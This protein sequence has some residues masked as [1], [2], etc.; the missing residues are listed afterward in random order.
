MAPQARHSEAE[1]AP[2]EAEYVPAGH[3]VQLVAPATSDQVPAGQLVQPA[4]PTAPN[5]PATHAVPIEQVAEPAVDDDPAGHA[6]Q[7]A[8]AAAEAAAVPAA[9]LVHAAAP[10]SV[11]PA[12]PNLPEVQAVPRHAAAEVALTVEE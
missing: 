8:P 5:W 10:S 12:G 7:E 4:T 1:L 3:G 6:G 11:A 2:A 9:Q